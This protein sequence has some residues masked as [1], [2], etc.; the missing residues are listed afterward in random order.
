MRRTIRYA[1][2][3]FG[4]PLISISSAAG[5]APAKSSSCQVALASS[6]ELEQ[7]GHFK[8]AREA[9]LGCTRSACGESV[10]VQCRARFERLE[11]ETPS[12]VP[13]VTDSRGEP[14]LDVEVRVDGQL[15]TP[16]IDG[17]G[18]LV[19]PGTH[20]ISFSKDGAVFHT[21]TLF[22]LQGERNRVV[23]ATW[24]PPPEP[25]ANNAP[26]AAERSAA[27]A[28]T[29][30]A[31][32]ESAGVATRPAVAVASSRAGSSLWPYVLGGAGV[33]GIGTSLLLV[34]WGRQD[35][36][37]LDRCAP[38]CPQ[39]S[40]DH[41]HNLYTAGYVSAGV[42]VAALGVAGFL[43]L[44]DRAAREPDQRASAYGFDIRA[45]TTGATGIVKGSF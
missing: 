4:A 20:E 16:R 7:S 40:V 26:P 6:Q 27:P 33:L 28:P 37:E 25:T 44:R 32:V 17:R 24:L 30:K 22:L 36:D 12:I 9:S 15:L 1:L 23:N 2:G 42:G 41:V 11:A 45:S 3:L 34:N 8:Q 39:S 14:Q 5:A 35:N 19:D 21:S 13:V 29:V 38:N 31:T 43:F 18:L 10:Q